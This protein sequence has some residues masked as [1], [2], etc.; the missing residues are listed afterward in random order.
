MTAVV[1]DEQ[2]RLLLVHKTE[3]HLWAL[4]GGGVDVGESVAQAAVREVEE[5]TG[6]DDAGERPAWSASTRTLDTFWPTTTARSA[7]RTPSVFTTRL[8]DGQLTTFLETSDVGWLTSSDWRGYPSIGQFG[9]ESSTGT[10]MKPS[11]TSIE[12]SSR[13]C[14][15]IWVRSESSLGPLAP[16]IFTV[17]SY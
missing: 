9:R 6:M 3:N 16:G 13:C 14:S 17:C 10:T 2:G 7:S 8:L 1:T 15:N 4:P 12:C 11:H 5:E